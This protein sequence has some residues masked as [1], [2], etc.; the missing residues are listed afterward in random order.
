MLRQFQTFFG[1]SSSPLVDW[2]YKEFSKAVS[3]YF[4]PALVSLC[5]S[6]DFFYEV[7]IQHRHIISG[8]SE[9]LSS[10]L[11]I[12]QLTTTRLFRVRHNLIYKSQL[13]EPM[14]SLPLSWVSFNQLEATRIT[15]KCSNQWNSLTSWLFPNAPTST[16][17]SSPHRP[18]PPVELFGADI[19]T[20]RPLSSHYQPL[21]FS[22]FL[23]LASR[24]TPKHPTRH[25][26]L[27]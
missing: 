5:T 20:L 26:A 23:D 24:A 17:L 21:D 14:T 7:P 22:S 11:T 18:I 2:P 27:V 8:G 9:P 6:N 12:S 4:L 19:S 15:K 10:L 3:G 16:A 1:L 13:M 25:W